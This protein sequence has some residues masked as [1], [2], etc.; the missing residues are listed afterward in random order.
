MKTDSAVL[1][2]GACGDIGKAL[3]EEFAAPGVGLAL[4]DLQPETSSRPLVSRLRDK[5]SKVLYRQAD[6]TSAP[7]MAEFVAHAVEELGGIGLCIANAGIVERGSLIDLP[8]DAWRRTLDVNLTGCFITAQAAA[9]AMTRGGNGGHILFLSSWVQDVPRATIGAYCASKSGLK[10]LAKCLALELGPAGIRVNLVA[11]GFVDVG[12]TGQ[13][14]RRNPDLRPGMEASIPLGRLI[15]APE[16]ARAIR[17]L[18]SNEASYLTGSTLLV[19][20]GAS[21]FFRKQE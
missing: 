7:E 11:P 19:D 14:L 20:G 8:V 1:I 5:G 3:A 2:T 9:R 12:L 13:N 6:V 21:L 10:M 18:S 4:C 16:L 17:L 15:S